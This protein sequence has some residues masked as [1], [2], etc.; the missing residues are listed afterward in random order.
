M[1]FIDTANMIAAPPFMKNLNY[2]ITIFWVGI[3]LSNSLQATSLNN[4][5][6]E[7]LE[8]DT[9]YKI[10]RHTFTATQERLTQGRAG[11]LPSIDF[12]GRARNVDL[13]TERIDGDVLIKNRGVTVTATQPLFRIENFIIYQQSKNEVAQGDA[14]FVQAAQDL[15]LR[16]TQAYFD[17]LIAQVNVEA[18]E[19]QEKA[20]AQQL[21]QMRQNLASGLSTIVDLNEAE[22]RY[23]LV[24]SQEIVARNSLEISRRNLQSI[25]NRFPDVLPRIGLEK[26]ITDPL[27]L[28]EMKMEE[29]VA[30]AEQKNISLKIQKFAHEIA[31][32]EA[33]KSMSKHYPTV[34]LVGQYT[35]QI[36]N[37]FIVAG[38][39][40][41]YESR[42][43]GL[44]LK[45]PIF[46]GLSTQSRVRESLANRDR[47]REELE[48]GQRIIGLHVRQHYLNLTNGIAQVKALK[49]ALISSRSQLDSTIL[50]QESGIRIEIDVL[51]AQQQYYSA[52]RDLAVAYYNYL[53]S[54]LRLKADVGELD[55]SV[56]EEIN[57]FL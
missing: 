46:H 32:Q 43:I 42:M 20:F 33:Q 47:V 15:I 25:I 41:D 24:I 38:R 26:I 17:V 35:N 56:L 18:V 6:R 57:A 12:T 53:M 55:E 9:Q 4:I 48:N 3:I 14:K 2:S 16:V 31:K 54:R 11:L 50:G 44:E 39:G 7:A 23:D 40:L 49:K 1:V 34:D 10:A 22:A 51:N 21:E 36:D 8:H 37:P 19:A 27:P 45:V 52:R 13:N 28:P 30:A 29:W 5:Y